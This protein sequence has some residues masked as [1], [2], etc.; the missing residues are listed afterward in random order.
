MKLQEAAGGFGYDVK[1]VRHVMFGVLNSADNLS[2]LHSP[3]STL[4]AGKHL[5]ELR[6]SPIG[7]ED[8]GGWLLVFLILSSLTGQISGRGLINI[9]GSLR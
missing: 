5:L 3:L 9:I 8:C 6:I 4:V 2:T 1:E 7:G